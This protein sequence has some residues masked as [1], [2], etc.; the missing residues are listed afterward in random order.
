[1]VL[2]GLGN[3]WSLLLWERFGGLSSILAQVIVVV[4][5]DG[6]IGNVVLEHDARQQSSPR[7]CFRLLGIV[8]DS[9]EANQLGMG[10]HLE[11]SL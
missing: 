3:L 2:I 7:V 9:K 10:G 1:M 6:G 5:R 8:S 4:G 11:Q